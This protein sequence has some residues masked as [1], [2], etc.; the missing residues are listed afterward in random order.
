MNRML[1]VWIGDTI[2]QDDRAFTHMKAAEAAC[3]YPENDDILTCR[4]IWE[5]IKTDVLPVWI[6]FAR[7][8]Q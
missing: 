2:D 5:A 4:A 8:I 6:P 1:T 3:R 7:R